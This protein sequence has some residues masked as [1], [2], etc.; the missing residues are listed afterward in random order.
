MTIIITVEMCNCSP[1]AKK[2]LYEMMRMANDIVDHQASCPGVV[3]MPPACVPVMQF[4]VVSINR[5]FLLGCQF[6]LMHVQ[7]TVYTLYK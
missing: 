4:A 6:T 3:V 2:S 5:T 1:F 7:V